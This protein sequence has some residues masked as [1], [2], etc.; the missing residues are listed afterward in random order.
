MK[1]NKF[2][3][4]IA[5]L[6]VMLM[7]FQTAAFVAAEETEVVTE[8]V[9]E[10]V[11]VPQSLREFRI[12]NALDV[13]T[14]YEEKGF[15]GN[16]E[17]SREETAAIAERLPGLDGGYSMEGKEML[18]TDVEATDTYAYEIYHMNNLGVMTGYNGEFNPEETVTEE[19]FLKVIVEVLG[20]GYE[21]GTMGG[22]PHGYSILAGKY[23]F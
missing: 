2:K 16:A 12:L 9:T 3:H 6:L 21:A 7:L 10:E 14:L 23:G 4:I 17:V 15:T 20:Y 11:Y 5:L 1:Y 8:E 22:Y 18:F 19:Q 13:F